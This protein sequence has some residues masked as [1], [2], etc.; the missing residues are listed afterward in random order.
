MP[1]RIQEDAMPLYEY[2]CESCGD[3]EEKLEGFDAPTEHDC[4]ECGAA[5]AMHRQVSLTSFTLAGGG[6]M[7]QGYGHRAPGKKQDAASTPAKTEGT[8]TPAAAPAPGAGC[9]GGCGCHSAK[10]AK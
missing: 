5:L 8:A 2:R 4:P 1:L 6:W 9:A 7:D 10:P 3:K